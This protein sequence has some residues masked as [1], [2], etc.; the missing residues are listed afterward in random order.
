MVLL[1]IAAVAVE[2]AYALPP[3]RG[4]KVGIG[5][6][7][8]LGVNGL[9]GKFWLDDGNAI[10]LVIGAWGVGRYDYGY[11][12]GVSADYLWEMPSL[13]RAE[14]LILA[15]NLGLGASVGAN[16]PAWLGVSGV[17]GLEFNFQPAPIDVVI[18]YR[19]GFRIL[20][21]AGPDLVNFTGHVRVHF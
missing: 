15:W 5:V 1:F 2:P 18:E 21:S 14:A 9:S 17:A 19:P 4:A 11:G 8:G 3:R 16:D 12:L 13:A 20:P 7:G 6:G 10:Q